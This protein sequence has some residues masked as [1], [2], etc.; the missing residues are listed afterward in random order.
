MYKGE[1]KWYNPEKGFGFISLD[2]G[3]DVF[4]HHTDIEGAGYR[5][6]WEG[7]RV[8]LD[9]E[10]LLTLSHAQGTIKELRLAM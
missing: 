5:T 2:K 10:F 8:S 3:G 1:V 4:V 6:L 9:T 7:Q